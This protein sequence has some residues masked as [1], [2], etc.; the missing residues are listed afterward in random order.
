M[1][2]GHLRPRRRAGVAAALR[3]L[4]QSLGKEA[5][6]RLQGCFAIPF[7]LLAWVLILPVYPAR[8]DGFG[9]SHEN[10]AG[11]APFPGDRAAAKLDGLLSGC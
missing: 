6:V 7:L 5:T 1:G 11:A 3:T 10:G 9:A 4:P 8:F 2:R